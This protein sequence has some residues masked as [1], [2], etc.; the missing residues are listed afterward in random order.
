[1][2]CVRHGSLFLYIAVFFCCSRLLY[3]ASSAYAYESDTVTYLNCAPFEILAFTRAFQVKKRTD[4]LAS[5][6]GSHKPKSR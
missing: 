6:E 3:P 1:M 4:G 2:L 5:P